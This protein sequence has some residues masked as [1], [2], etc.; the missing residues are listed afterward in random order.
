[1]IF[2]LEIALVILIAVLIF[3]DLIE[4]SI[5]GLST[6]QHIDAQIIE[7]R[8]ELDKKPIKPEC[9]W[10]R[11]AG[12]ILGLI[13]IPIASNMWFEGFDVILVITN[14]YYLLRKRPTK[15]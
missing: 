5:R 11:W 4:A 2:A 7:L 6:R 3:W 12:M 10:C 13:L 8:S 14:A 1:M 15:P 9:R